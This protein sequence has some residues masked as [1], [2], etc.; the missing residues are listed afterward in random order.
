VQLLEREA[1]A[2]AFEAPSFCDVVE[3][4]SQRLVGDKHLKLRPRHDERV[5]LAYRSSAESR[6]GRERVQMVV[7]A[8]G[9]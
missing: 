6:Q 4:V 1:W 5:R 7:E 2:Q 9:D 3:A 8:V